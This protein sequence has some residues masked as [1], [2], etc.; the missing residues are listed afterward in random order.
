MIYHEF[1]LTAYHESLIS[2]LRQYSYDGDSTLNLVFKSIELKDTD[3]NPF[4]GQEMVL[5][6]PIMVLYYPE[7]VGIP[8]P[9]WY[10]ELSASNVDL[11][12]NSPARKEVSKRL[13]S[14]ETAVFLFLESGN[15][16]QDQ[17][18]FSILKTELER[19][20]TVLKI[21][22]TGI[23]INGNT[24]VVTDFQD[25]A[26]NFST[27]RVSR[28]DSLEDVFIHT[29]IGTEFDLKQYKVPMVFPIF[30]QGRSLYALVGAGINGNT[31]EKACQSLVNWCSCEI[32]ALHQ[33]VDLLFWA[34]WS[35]RSGGTWVQEETIPPLTGLSNFVSKKSQSINRDVYKDVAAQNTEKDQDSSKM[36][37]H[38][39]VAIDSG[40]GFKGTVKDADESSPIFKHTFILLLGLIAVVTIGT[41]IL[42]RKNNSAE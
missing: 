41:F 1:S 15:L 29:L 20:S 36:D 33:G 2:D 38:T 34:D 6:L 31:I 35:K 7:Q 14:A 4:Q 9:A 22:I 42:K 30:G 13:L 18:Y 27:I 24:R 5:Q 19:L 39:A 17:K 12:Y 25:V 37:R 10:G 3:Q 23:D 32:K 16:E 21:P 8:Y 28:Q 26:L 40:H 11:L